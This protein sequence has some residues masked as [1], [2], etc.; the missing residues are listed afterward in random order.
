MHIQNPVIIQN[1]GIF[2]TWDIFRTQSRHILAYS[3]CFVT[4]KYWEPCYIQNFTI[5]SI[6][7]CIGPRAYSESYLFRYIQA[8]WGIFNNDSS[9]SIRYNNFLFDRIYKDMFFDYNDFNFNAQLSL[10]IFENNNVIESVKFAFFSE[11]KFY[12]GKESSL[13]KY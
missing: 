10:L 8:Y 4:L 13:T 11:N 12:D 2:S 3:E 5:F 6:L 1:P 9:N 7:I